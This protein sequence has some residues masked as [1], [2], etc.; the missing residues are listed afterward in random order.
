MATKA[1]GNVQDRILETALAIAEKEGWAGVGPSAVADRAKVP[2]TEL[3]R[4]YRDADAIAN[5]WFAR[6]LDAM[7]A[8]PPRGFA[9]RP[10]PERLEILLLRWFDALALHRRV[11]AEMLSQKMWVF[12]PHH[13]VPMVFSLSRLIQWLRDAAGLRAGGR[14]KQVEETG[15]TLLFLATLAV[16]CRDETEGQERTRAFLRARLGQ[17]DNAMGRLFGGAGKKDKA[18]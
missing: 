2:L 4:H 5:A 16:W 12:H 14:R 11:T 1:K 3:R 15:L 8:P 13:Y 9:R 6:A 10:P 17:A 18:A 7:L